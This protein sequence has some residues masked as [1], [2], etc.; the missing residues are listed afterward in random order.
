MDIVVD[1]QMIP[2]SKSKSEFALFQTSS[3]QFHLIQFVK[4]WRI[5]LELNSKRLSLSSGKEE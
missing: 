1:M 3:V 2:G 4:R 5:F